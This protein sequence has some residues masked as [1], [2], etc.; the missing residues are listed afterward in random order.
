MSESFII[1]K[2]NAIYALIGT[3]L[4]CI[5]GEH[6][7]VF[8]L[9]L[10]LNL[11]DFLSRW[12]AAR[13]TGTESSKKCGVGMFKK[14]GYWLLIL[15]SF[16][17]GILF[18]D[19][20]AILGID[21]HI[22]SLIGWYVLFV[23]I[24]NEFRSILENLVE[25]NVWVPTFLIKGLEVASKTIDEKMDKIIPDLNLNDDSKPDQKDEDV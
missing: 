16:S 1:N 15:T 8:A 2:I 17:I 14:V 23:C 5:F 4:T 22:T 10:V 25:A 11:G 12:I 3:V 20:G 6:W 24:I 13:A 9:Y 18:G 7:Q 21:L 19:L